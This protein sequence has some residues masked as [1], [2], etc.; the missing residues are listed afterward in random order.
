MIN[1]AADGGHSGEE[2]ALSIMSIFNEGE[3]MSEGLM[4]IGNMKKIEPLKVTTCR[5]H[6]EIF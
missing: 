6:L 2:Y 4:F 3:S 1:Q 5:N